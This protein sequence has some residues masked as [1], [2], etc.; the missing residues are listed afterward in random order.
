MTMT[1]IPNPS[2]PC[3]V[4]GLDATAA[5]P[6]NLWPNPAKESVRLKVAG[7]DGFSYRICDLTGRVLRSGFSPEVEAQIHVNDLPTGSYLV[8]LEQNSNRATHRLMVP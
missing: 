3:F 6:S 4:T 5:L 2:I 8:I 1:Y 7:T